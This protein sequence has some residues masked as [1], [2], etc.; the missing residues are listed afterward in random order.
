[1]Q[2]EGGERTNA[3]L[4]TEASTLHCHCHRIVQ[5]ENTKNHLSTTFSPNHAPLLGGRITQTLLFEGKENGPKILDL[6]RMNN[7]SNQ[8]IIAERL[9]DSISGK[10]NASK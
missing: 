9:F 2:C 7:M 4:G 6:K 10:K 1:V 8:H 3:V 5:K